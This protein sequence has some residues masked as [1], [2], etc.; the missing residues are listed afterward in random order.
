MN[1][2]NRFYFYV[3]NNVEWGLLSKGKHNVNII[4]SKQAIDLPVG[5]K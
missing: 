3:T 1:Q 5:V 2:E 4:I